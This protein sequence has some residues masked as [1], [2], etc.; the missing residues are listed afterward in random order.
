MFLPEDNTLSMAVEVSIM[1]DGMEATHEERLYYDAGKKSHVFSEEDVEVIISISESN[2][3][4]CQQAREEGKSEEIQ[5]RR[6]NAW[7]A[8]IRTKL[9]IIG[10]KSEEDVLKEKISALKVIMKEI[11]NSVIADWLESKK[12]EEMME[13]AST[14]QPKGTFSYG[15]ICEI[16]AAKLRE[17]VR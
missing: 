9:S 14:E 10:M 15:R 1:D 13:K 5:R 16:V 3:M 17:K 8:A 12:A 4:D 7:K 11:E 2:Y 6:M